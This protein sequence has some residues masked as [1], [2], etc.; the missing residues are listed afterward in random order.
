[1]YLLPTVF[2]F[3]LAVFRERIFWSLLGTYVLTHLIKAFVS[4]FHSHRWSLEPFW[5]TGGMPSSHTAISVA[6][7][8]AIA[9]DTGPSPL[10]F[11]CVIFSLIVIRDSVGVRASV[12][13]QAKILNKLSSKLK[14]H[15]KVAI[16]L[17]HTP[18]QAVVGFAIGVLV[19]VVVYVVV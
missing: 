6:L 18:F 10:F 1:M 5:K 2:E 19:A 17:G 11:V 16:V 7:T 14:M 13:E 15:K 9:F 12:G 3:A 4:F 8:T